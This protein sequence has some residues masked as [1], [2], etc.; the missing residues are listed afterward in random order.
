MLSTLDPED[1]CLGN[2]SNCK[3]YRYFCVNSSALVKASYPTPPSSN[4]KALN[5]QTYRIAQPGNREHSLHSP[6]SRNLS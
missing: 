1:P 6:E 4:L 5:K 2:D 3:P